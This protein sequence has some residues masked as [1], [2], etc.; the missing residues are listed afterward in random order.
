MSDQ[1]D[2]ICTIQSLRCAAASSA[3]RLPR[4]PSIRLSTLQRSDFSSFETDDHVFLPSPPLYLSASLAVCRR[5]RQ[6]EPLDMT[7]SAL[8]LYASQILLRAEL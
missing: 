3:P 4:H 2:M 5:R 8:L 1:R 7:L 6:W